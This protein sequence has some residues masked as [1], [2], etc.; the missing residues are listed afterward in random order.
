MRMQENSPL[1]EDIKNRIMNFITESSHMR[2][3]YNIEEEE[4]LINSLP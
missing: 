2:R 1:S 3:K 4:K